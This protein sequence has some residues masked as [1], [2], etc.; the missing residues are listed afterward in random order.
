MLVVRIQLYYDNNHNIAGFTF[1]TSD[2]K[3]TKSASLCISSTWTLHFSVKT[4][5]NKDAKTLKCMRWVLL[6]KRFRCSDILKITGVLV[7]TC[8][9]KCLKII[10]SVYKLR[11]MDRFNI[12]LFFIKLWLT[13]HVYI[14]MHNKNSYG[15]EEHDVKHI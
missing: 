6:F 1:F 11:L 2:V 4:R 10:C 14:M 9:S 15:R 7:K 13:R 3:F 12:I 5:S 8:L